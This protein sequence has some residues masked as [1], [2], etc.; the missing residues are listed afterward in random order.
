[1]GTEKG[2]EKRPRS[3]RKRPP[4]LGEPAWF[5]RDAVEARRRKVTRQLLRVAQQQYEFTKN[6]V[7]VWEAVRIASHLSAPLPAWV[8]AYLARV[9]DRIGQ[10][11]RADVP[12]KNEPPRAVYRALEFGGRGGK[13]ANPFTAMS[14]SWHSVSIALAVWWAMDEWPKVDFAIDAVVKTHPTQC[15]RNPKCHAISRSTVARAWRLHRRAIEA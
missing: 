3:A 1:V 2:T 10:L 15:T 5:A 12:T 8:M 4:Q 13:G 14:D 9:A 6:P 11:S 7:F